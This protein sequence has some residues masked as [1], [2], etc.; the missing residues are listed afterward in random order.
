[1]PS[2]N[3]EKFTCV[4]NIHML[5]HA[6]LWLNPMFTSTSNKIMKF[7]KHGV[8]QIVTLIVKNSYLI[9]QG[10]KNCKPHIKITSKESRTCTKNFK[11]FYG[12]IKISQAKWH[13]IHKLDTFNQTL[14]N[15]IF[16]HMDKNNKNHHKNCTSQGE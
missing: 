2:I 1:M 11:H 5:N 10:S 13:G 15:F 9:N 12:S 3:P 7:T 8:T 4:L 6:K 16:P 14:G